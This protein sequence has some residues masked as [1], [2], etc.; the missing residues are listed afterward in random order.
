MPVFETGGREFESLRAGQF[1]IYSSMKTALLLSGNP[2]FSIDFDSQLSNLQNSDIDVFIVFWRRPNDLDPKISPNWC[3]LIDG[4]DIIRRLQPHL[5]SNY[6]IKYAEVLEESF[7]PPLPR[8][9]DSYNSTPVNVWQQY[10]IL[11]YCDQQRL[12]TG[13]YDLVIRSRTDLGL[14][15]PINL[16]LAYQTLLEYPNLIF[17]PINQRYGYVIHEDGYRT[18]FNDQ[19]AIG[20]PHV[21]KMYT[22]SVDQ[23]DDL[24][25]K[26][27]RYNPEYLVQ[28]HLY[29]NGISWPETS[30]EIIRDPA[31]YVPI[32]HG[33]WQYV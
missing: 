8:Y 10:N 30:W 5:P 1:K 17:T 23:F 6:K 31:H 27:T 21:M 12:K 14:S 22:H 7:F 18:G 26:G 2:R 13:I 15:H 16:P 3:N 33:K 11:K 28:T 24:Y 32:E 20:L 4:H 25:M 29:N 9:Y 19:F